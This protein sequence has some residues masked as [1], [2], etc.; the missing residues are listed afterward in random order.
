MPISGG[1]GSETQNMEAIRQMLRHHTGNGRELADIF[2]MESRIRHIR[3]R[4]EAH[5]GDDGMLKNDD[6]RDLYGVYGYKCSK[7][8]CQSFLKGFAT[9]KRRDL[10]LSEHER[11]FRCDV[12]GCHGYAIGFCTEGDLIKHS[13]RLHSDDDDESHFP[14]MQSMAAV[15]VFRAASKG[16]LDRVKELVESGVDIN[17]SNDDKEGTF[18][19][20]LAAKGGHIDVCHYLL[21]HGATV[22]AQCRKTRKTAL[23]IAALNDDAEIARLLV[24]KHG[25]GGY[26]QHRN[27]SGLSPI[28]LAFKKD[29]KSVI[30]AFPPEMRLHK[31]C[32]GNDCLEAMAEFQGKTLLGDFTL[33]T[34]AIVRGDADRAA[35]MI[36]SS[37]VDLNYGA[38]A[39]RDESPLHLALRSKFP[40]IRTIIAQA[41][42]QT[43]RVDVNWKDS[44]GIVPLQVAC[45]SNAS[46]PLIRDLLAKTRFPL[47]GGGSLVWS[48]LGNSSFFDT[49][50]RDGAAE[51]LVKILEA[52]S[53]SDIDAPGPQGSLLLHHVCRRGYVGAVE[54]LVT[55]IRSRDKRDSDGYTPLHLTVRHG[56]GDFMAV[57]EI[58]LRHEG[59]GNLQTTANRNYSLARSASERPAGQRELILERLFWKDHAITGGIAESG[60]TALHFGAWALDPATVERSIAE[61]S[62]NINKSA[63]RLPDAWE[64]NLEM[65][66]AD[67]TCP[68][69]RGLFLTPLLLAFNTTPGPD[70]NLSGFGVWDTSRATRTA[71]VRLILE[72][73]T[74]DLSHVFHNVQEHYQVV[75]IRLFAKLAGEWMSVQLAARGL[76]L[77]W[78]L[79]MWDGAPGSGLIFVE[80]PDKYRLKRAVPRELV[81]AILC[82]GRCKF[83]DVLRDNLNFAV[84]ILHWEN[85]QRGDLELTEEEEILMHVYR[86]ACTDGSSKDLERIIVLGLDGARA[87]FQAIRAGNSR[88]VNM[89]VDTGLMLDENV[90]VEDES[91]LTAYELAREMGHMGIAESLR[92]RSGSL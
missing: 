19:L 47:V 80:D 2:P 46:E 18:P 35:A 24:S 81:V 41:L 75:L 67:I 15:D 12:R 76:T 33:I 58:L 83:L 66:T 3:A 87:L 44:E 21:D 73:E 88:L 43:G 48:L 17:A 29:H 14:Y 74:L 31:D 39:K 78:K 70:K 9:S 77:P 50:K 38:S 34:G 20:Y 71:V 36:T 8:W 89:L 60:I 5:L 45:E 16:N 85:L 30:A 82:G 37:C 54:V 1:A 92:A 86:Y 68:M 61:N 62:A 7:P 6:V 51:L 42:L 69:A 91:G 53:F 59:Y 84:Y 55:R 64:Q 56:E 10:H 27:S 11:P 57:V 23:H 4:L 65:A 22:D 28:G 72:C 26:M 79:M 52:T 40:Q 32:K 49:T 25:P 63:S 90:A 13:T